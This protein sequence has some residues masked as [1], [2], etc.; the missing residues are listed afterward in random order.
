MDHRMPFLCPL[1]CPP[2]SGVLF[3]DEGC[4]WNLRKSSHVSTHA[5]F[6]EHVELALDA[7]LRTS[8]LKGAKDARMVSLSSDL[9][10]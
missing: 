4:P 9:T 7:L 8:T 2:D 3:L 6:C 1:H 10:D 5:L